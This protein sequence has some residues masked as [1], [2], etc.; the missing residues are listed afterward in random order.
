MGAA[1]H[2]KDA[3]DR[4]KPGFENTLDYEYHISRYPVS[5]AQYRYF[6]QNDGY[7]QKKYWI[8]AIADGR[9]KP[10]QVKIWHEWQ[11]APEDY[12]FPYTLDNHPVVGVSWYEAMAFCRW[13][14]EYL[15][16]SDKTSDT[17]KRLLH[18]DY[19]ITLPS[20]AEWEKAAR[21]VDDQRIYPWGDDRDTDK[22][23]YDQTK[24]GTPS[25]LGC[26]PQGQ[27]PFKCE[28]MAGNVLEWCR[29]SWQGD[30]SEYKNELKSSDKE[31]S[32]VFRG[33]AFDDY[34]RLVRCS[35]RGRNHP[36][37]RNGY[38]GFRVCVCPHFSEI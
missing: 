28:D 25:A 13:L 1:E 22:A 20:E 8:E 19:H 5:H 30:Y 29:T 31:T 4:E 2:D 38:I 34:R 37:Y 24:I 15:K 36:S 9:W 35:F 6:I 26:F 7:Q 18:N 12:D 32:R 11:G 23:N 33:G 16:T 21:G 10:G 3:S 27:S 14:T 17:I